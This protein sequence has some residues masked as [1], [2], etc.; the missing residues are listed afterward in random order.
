MLGIDNLEHGL[1]GNSEYDPRKRAG[2]CP[3]ADHRA[4]EWLD[5]DGR[6]V[7]RTFDTLIERGVALTSTLPVLETLVAG[8]PDPID[9][10]MHELLHPAVLER[11][12]ETYAAIRDV[13][14]A[15]ISTAA[16]RRIMDYDVA[17]ARA[18]GLLAAGVDSSGTGGALAGLGDQRNLEL[19]VEAGFTVP[20]AVRVMTLNGARLLGVDDELGSVEPGKIADLVVVAGDLV[21]DPAAIRQVVHVFKDGIAYDPS[22]LLDSVKGRRALTRG[23]TRAR[24]FARPPV[25]PTARTLC[26]A[27]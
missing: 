20:E 12:L 2:Q 16:F 21:E 14:G 1:F 26:R 4:F 8:R 9:P 19:L 13:P 11:Y 10:R 18:G 22:R 3:P 24:T 6:Q 23:A 15:G 25:R 5:L 17:F 7:R 27:A